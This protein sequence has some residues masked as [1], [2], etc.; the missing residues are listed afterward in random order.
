MK[1]IWVIFTAGFLL[2][3]GQSCNSDRIVEP[4][5]DSGVTPSPVRDVR[6]ENLPGGA[7]ISYTL[8]SGSDNMLYVKAVYTAQDGKMKEA[9]S[10]YFKDNILIE[11]FSDLT[12]RSVE[13]YVVTRSGLLSEPVQVLI[14]PKTSPLVEAL[15]SL[16]FSETFGGVNIEFSND[17]EADLA[18]TIL[19]TDSLENLVPVQNVYTQMKSGTISSRGFEPVQ[20]VFGV[21]LRDRWENYSDTVYTNITPWEELELD[22]SKFSAVKLPTD[23]YE[24]NTTGVIEKLW[25]GVAEPPPYMFATVVGTG[26]PQWFTIDLGEMA[27]LS[28]LLFYPRAHPG[29]FY[30]NSPRSFEIWG[31]N[32]PNMDGSWESWTKLLDCEVIKPSGLPLGQQ[33]TED[34]VFAQSGIEFEFPEGSGVRYI[35][36]KTLDVWTGSNVAISELTFFGVYK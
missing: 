1:F 18:F 20:R 35:R 16:R 14:Q 28:R 25:D 26:F 24:P 21:F 33:T 8:P 19:T 13:L 31:S 9:K 2:I 4:S 10:S 7:R 11:G 23:T 3:I 17:S 22:K 6:V 5:I 12:E 15:N 27:T 36:F 30:S 34:E 29:Q 32:D